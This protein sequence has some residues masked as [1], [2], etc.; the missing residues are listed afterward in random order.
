MMCLGY[1]PKKSKHHNAI[2][3]SLFAIFLEYHELNMRVL[4][5]SVSVQ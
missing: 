4:R 1:V 5:C 3:Q 2:L